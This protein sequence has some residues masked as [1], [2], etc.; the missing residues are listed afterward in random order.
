MAESKPN[1]LS[2]GRASLS[3]AN[4][5]F[6][7]P[8][9]AKAGARRSPAEI[10][11]AATT[12]TTQSV[13]VHLQAE[14]SCLRL[15][16][17]F[18]LAGRR[19]GAEPRVGSMGARSQSSSSS[20]RLAYCCLVGAILIGPRGI[21]RWR[22]VTRRRPSRMGTN[23]PGRAGARRHRAT[24]SASLRR[25]PASFARR[26]P[27]VK[28]WPFVPCVSFPHITCELARRIRSQHHGAETQ[29]LRGANAITAADWAVEVAWLEIECVSIVS[30]FGEGREGLH[31]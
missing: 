5:G 18:S 4:V 29:Q 14:P 2:E 20:V 12:Q 15:E 3:R 31:Y 21:L 9:Q 6:G 7:S 27:G 22:R 25:P 13:D 26:R 30:V 1:R 11:V 10:T 19:A 24:R 28:L 17:R 23:G 16:M 8:V